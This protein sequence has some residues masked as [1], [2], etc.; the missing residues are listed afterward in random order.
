MAHQDHRIPDGPIS[1]SRNR[2]FPLEEPVSGST[3]AKL[4][5]RG[6]FIRAFILPFNARKVPFDLNIVGLLSVQL[7]RSV[8]DKGPYGQLEAGARGW[9][10]PP[11]LSGRAG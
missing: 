11:C 2:K 6:G 4:V 1:R 3:V 9:S 7:L 8:A 5:R 10:A